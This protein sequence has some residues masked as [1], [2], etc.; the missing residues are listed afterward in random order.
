VSERTIVYRGRLVAASNGEEG[1]LLGMIPEGD[2]EALNARLFRAYVYE[3]D[4][5][6]L[7]E[8]I[9][10]DREDD[11]KYLS[12]RY[13]ITDAPASPDDLESDL[14]AMATGDA[15]V[16][17]RMMYSESTGYLWTDEDFVV[18]G[19]D[20]AEELKSHL[21][22]YLHMEIRFSTVPFPEGSR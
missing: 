8:L 20:L 5:V 12:V 11:E 3:G 14:A 9:R 7:V 1:D 15:D 18:G 10:D 13:F 2:V 21:G 16:R 19:H 22:K 4:P 17:Y 6:I